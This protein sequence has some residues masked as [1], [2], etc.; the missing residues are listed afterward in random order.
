M[1]L[2]PSSPRLR[3]RLGWAAGGAA[4]LA[5]AVATVVLLPT[6]RDLTPDTPAVALPA[7]APEPVVRERKAKL[8]PRTRAEINETL[9]RFIR[10]AVRRD[11]PGL[12]WELAGP[13]LRTGWTR[14]DWLADQ[15][16]VFPYPARTTGFEGWRKLYSYER[17]VG[18]DL[19]IQP[20]DHRI[21]A[22]G[23]GVEMVKA[24][25]RWLV[26]EWVPVAS[27]TP[28]DGRQWVT[29][30][31][32][33]SAGGWTDKGLK[34]KPTEARLGSEWLLAPLSLLGVGLL[35]PVAFGLRSAR[36]NR[37]AS[38]AYAASLTDDRVTWRSS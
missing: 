36:R 16:P 20:R 6:G 15:I 28:V 29:G 3:R 14:R 1:S 18:L 17:R 11:D 34:K 12:A 10:A 31:V 5:A 37:R 32:D 4:A 8:T 25:D 19:V 23:V 21:G 35:V 30:I 26:D 22:L 24:R 38:A 13:K 33:F 9:E 27:F 2:L 7:P